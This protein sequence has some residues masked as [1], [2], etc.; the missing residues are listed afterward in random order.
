MTCGLVWASSR[1]AA[2]TSA[3]AKRDFIPGLLTRQDNRNYRQTGQANTRRRRDVLS[4]V[5]R[6]SG[7][8]PP[9]GGVHPGEGEVSGAPPQPTPKPTVRGSLPFVPPATYSRPH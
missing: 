4:R 7:G 1:T 6:L 5:S 2:V 8:P 9:P 3:V